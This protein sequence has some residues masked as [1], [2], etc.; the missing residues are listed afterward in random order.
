MPVRQ[1]SSLLQTQLLS[2]WGMSQQACRGEKRKLQ[3]MKGGRE[4]GTLFLAQDDMLVFP[5]SFFHTVWAAH[6]HSLTKALVKETQSG[7]PHCG[8]V[9]PQLHLILHR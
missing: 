4:E 7:I 3:L 1:K 9:T 5:L 6:L 2:V 8:A